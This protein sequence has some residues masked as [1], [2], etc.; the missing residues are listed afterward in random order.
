MEQF[1]QALTVSFSVQNILFMNLGVAI[2]IIFGAL[3]GLSGG[4]AIVL[5]MPFTFYLEPIV[6]LSWLLGMYCGGTYGG[7][8][9][10]ILIN[11]PGTAC[12]LYTSRCV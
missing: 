12:L 6:S 7:S 4:V 10:A 3:P 8:V 11:T 2:G 1:I 5:F 9:T